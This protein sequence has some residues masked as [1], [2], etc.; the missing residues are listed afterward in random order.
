MNREYFI[1]GLVNCSTRYDIERITQ[2]YAN[3][4]GIDYN[5]IN[6]YSLNGLCNGLV[7]WKF[8]NRF[9][10]ESSLEILDYIDSHNGSKIK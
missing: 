2:E 6:N 4:I 5:I 1:E 8:K 9:I 3:A 10:E 7:Y